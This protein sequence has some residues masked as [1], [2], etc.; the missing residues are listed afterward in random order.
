MIQYQRPGSLIFNSPDKYCLF[1]AIISQ[2]QAQGREVKGMINNPARSLEA[3][4]RR[5]WDSI[6]SSGKGEMGD[7]IPAV[8][9]LC[10]PNLSRQETR[11]RTR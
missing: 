7:S 1:F 9:F 5:R 6:G 11:A 3:C 10:V 4:P 2:Y 8:Q